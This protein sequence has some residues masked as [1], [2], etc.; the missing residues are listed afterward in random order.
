MP[1]TNT[2]ENDTDHDTDAMTDSNPPNADPVTD[3]TFQKTTT[4]RIGDPNPSIIDDATTTTDIGTM[5]QQTDVVLHPCTCGNTEQELS[6]IYQCS[7]CHQ[8]CCPHC[9]ITISRR[10]RCPDCAEQD[11]HL[12]KAVF[13]AL[14]LLDNTLT[15]GDRFPPHI[16]VTA[17]AT[18]IEHNYLHLDAIVHE[19][20]GPH[21]GVIRLTTDNPLSVAGKEALHVGDQLYS[22][23]EDVTRLITDLTIQQ[24]ANNGR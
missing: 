1:D 16:E 24:V 11:Y 18:L 8:R 22:D 9:R 20:G 7:R 5:N 2:T 14:Y 15:A 23:D 17:A 3:E 4:R 21:Q 10:T 19:A 13:I 6:A 12:T